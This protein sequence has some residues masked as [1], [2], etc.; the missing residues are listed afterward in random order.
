[1][2]WRAYLG[3]FWKS[4]LVRKANMIAV[5]IFIATYFSLLPSWKSLFGLAAFLLAYSSIYYYNDL[6]DYESDKKRAFMPADKLL[7]HGDAS[8][9][10]YIHLLAWVPVVGIALTF[11][12]SPVLG[13]FT[14]SAILINHWRTLIRGN[15]FARELLLAFVEFLNFEA[16]WAA[17]YG[18]PIPGL[19]IPVFAAYSL[20]YALAHGAYKLRSKP[21]LHVL[22][23]PWV[24]VLAAGIFVAAFLSL[25]LVSRSSVHAVAIA[26]A[27][28]VY[29]LFVSLSAARYLRKDLESGMQRI[30]RAHDVALTVATLV[31]MMV[32]VLIVYAHIPTAPLP[33]ATPAYLRLALSQID[34]YQ[35]LL[36][37]SLL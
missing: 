24:W 18:G 28:F 12:Y 1:M 30:F 23:M 34:R 13:I 31:F 7:Y 15:L 21:L 17:L 19:A 11:I 25:P 16:F 3:K 26:V 20:A 37:S 8:V 27:S 14:V 33:V 36:F 6:L 32:G 35:S 5:T 9:R 4:I 10:D 2:N 22:R 29:V